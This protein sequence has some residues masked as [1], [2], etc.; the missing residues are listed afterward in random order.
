MKVVSREPTYKQRLFVEAYLGEANGNATEAAKRAGYRC[1]AKI[2]HTL[3]AIPSIRSLID[4][5]V[6]SAAMPANELLARLS[7]IATGS[8]G[9][10]MT[11]DEYGKE[12]LDLKKA[13]KAQK[14][15]LL[16]K[17]KWG[18]HGPEIEI[19]DPLTAMEKLGR[20]HGLFKDK[21][22]VKQEGAEELG[23]EKALFLARVIAKAEAEFDAG[24]R[25]GEQGN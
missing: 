13:K 23:P 11:I 2:G 12:S 14:L 4:R 25:G 18:Q 24:K 9:E 17:L 20:Y 3:P 19:H 5:R 7:E 6:T 8:L 22:D 15:G 21:P 16:K 1:P 10:F